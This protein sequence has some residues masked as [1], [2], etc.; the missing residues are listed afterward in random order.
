MFETLRKSVG[1]EHHMTLTA[2]FNLMDQW[3]GNYRLTLIDNLL[4][5]KEIALMKICRR[6]GKRMEVRASGGSDERIRGV[7]VAHSRV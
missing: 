2:A 3:I 6:L 5:G 4:M 7:R 1:L